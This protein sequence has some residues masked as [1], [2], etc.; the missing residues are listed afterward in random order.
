[1]EPRVCDDGSTE[2]CLGAQPGPAS[3][4]RPLRLPAWSP[5]G[6]APHVGVWVP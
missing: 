1:M 3:G 4:T 5:P 6:A 2:H